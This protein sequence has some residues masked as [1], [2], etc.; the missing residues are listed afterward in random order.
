MERI[1]RFGKNTFSSLDIR[2]YRLFFIGQAI[3][4]SGT[5]MQSIAQGLLVLKL[6][7]SG[8]MLGL[9][10][11]LQ[12]LPILLFGSMS[13]FIVDRFPKQKIL[14]T[15][16]IAAGILALILGI[17]VWTHV[18]QLWMVGILAFSLG[19]VNMIDNPTRNTFVPEMVGKENMTNAITLNSWEINLARVI[20]P[21]IAGILVATVGLAICFILNAFSYIAVVV[22]LF[23]IHTKHLHPSP[24][25][26]KEKG[27][28]R[29]GF[30]YIASNP[31]LRNTLIMLA[32]VGTLT[33]EF[34]VILPLVAQFTFH[35]LATGYAALTAAMG[36]GAVIGGLFTA[37][38]KKNSPRQLVLAALFFGISMMLVAFSP[39]LSLAIVAMVLV[40]ASSI[41]FNSIGNITLQ[42]ESLPEMRGRVMSLWTVAFLGSTP[43]GGPIIGWIGEN[44]GP[45]FGLGVGALAA[46]AAAGIGMFT[47]KQTM[48]Q[49]VS[50]SV[51]V[52]DEQTEFI[53]G[54]KTR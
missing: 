19:L 10:T 41:N 9:I 51:D 6:T 34:P 43:I 26:A 15:T 5:W 50:V 14:L 16:Q 29:E 1:K 33:Y 48:Q 17:L 27:L 54:T 44:I 13:G 25:I 36:I 12:F 22:V 24:A 38:R 31:L 7:N 40:G 8:T 45:R 3:S 37:N 35:N 2:N 49:K 20:G 30:A 53:E 47:L 42:L 21:S 32:I 4:L 11:A 52:T 23:M 28:I 18:V 46:F 39:T